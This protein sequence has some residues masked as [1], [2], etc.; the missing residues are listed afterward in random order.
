MRSMNDN[1]IN[2]GALSIAFY[3]GKYPQL[4][5]FD[6]NVL[7][8]LEETHGGISFQHDGDLYF[9]VLNN[10]NNFEVSCITKE[11]DLAYMILPEADDL[12]AFLT[13]LDNGYKIY[14]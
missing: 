13:S 4:L 12:L 2:W 8:E 1:D 5:K 11:Q 10:Q 7:P 3:L 14:L 9:L 6:V